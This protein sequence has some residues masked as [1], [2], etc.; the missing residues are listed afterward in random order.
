MKKQLLNFFTAA[1]LT[2]SLTACFAPCSIYA[3]VPGYIPTNGLKGWWPFNG[4]ANDESGNGNNGAVNGAILTNDRFSNLNSSYSFNNSSIICANTSIPN[5]VFSLSAWVY[6]NQSFGGIEFICLGS[7]SNTKWGAISSPLNTYMDYGRGCS[8]SSGNTINPTVNLNN[9]FHIVYVSQGAGQNTDIYIN[10]NLVGS[11]VNNNTGGCSTNNL[12]FGVDI[13]SAPEYIDGK[14]DDIA[15]W[16]RA[17]T[18]QEIALLYSG[19]STSIGTQPSNQTVLTSVGTAQF[20]VSTS[21]ATSTYQWQTNLGVG[22]Q[23]LSNVGQY[24][25]TTTNTLALSNVSMTNNNQPFRCIVT[26]GGC[27][28]TSD[29]AVLSVVN[30]AG[31]EESGLSSVK[32]FPSPANEFLNI[33]LNA[34]NEETYLL[35]DA[36]GRKVLE[37][38][39]TAKESQ[40]SL[41]S[42]Q[43]GNYLLK[44][45]TNEL[46]IRVVKQ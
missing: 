24:S 45:S 9:W 18:E 32:I 20:T 34:E 6:Q 39:L 30:S 23:N 25:G 15:I 27:S 36:S 2:S 4:N 12:Y 17:L 28:D 46:P 14:L 29:V 13:F 21:A 10:G 33:I 38:K 7:P 44:V 19:C 8:G 22:Y 41:T 16:N 26:S 42:L 5:N 40:I 3:Q 11:N 37:G 31:I 1:C 35:F 43:S